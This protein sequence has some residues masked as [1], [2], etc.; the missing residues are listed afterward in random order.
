MRLTSHASAAR[1]QIVQVHGLR[2]APIGSAI[3]FTQGKEA[4]KQVDVTDEGLLQFI[5]NRRG[6]PALGEFGKIRTAQGIGSFRAAQPGNHGIRR[7][8][9]PAH[10]DDLAD[11]QGLRRHA[12]GGQKGGACHGQEQLHAPRQVGIR[13]HWDSPYQG[14]TR[15]RGLHRA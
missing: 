4:G 9:G 8:S 14:S 13:R 12:G 11:G 7:A 2:V 1:I 10:G 5:Q 6:H 15:L 3:G